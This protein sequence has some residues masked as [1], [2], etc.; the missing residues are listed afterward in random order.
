MTDKISKKNTAVP[1]SEDTRGKIKMSVLKRI[2]KYMLRYKGMM[3]ICFVLMILSG[4]IAFI[5]RSESLGATSASAF[6][7]IIRTKHIA[8]IPL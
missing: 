2:A 1:K 3:A 5:A 4:A 7:S 8:I 6:E